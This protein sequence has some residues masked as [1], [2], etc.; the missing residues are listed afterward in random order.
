MMNAVGGTTLHFFAQ[1]WRLN[2][3]DFKV[4][5]ETTRRYGAARIPT[6]CTVEDWPFGHE[7]LE[8]YYDKVDYEVGVSGK[9]G[10]IKGK[11]IRAVTFSKR[12]AAASTPCH[13]C[14]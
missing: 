9:A 4:A 11:T 8:P 12:R 1:A 10:N 2:L 14:G 6:G 7:E 13:H 3:W 5:S